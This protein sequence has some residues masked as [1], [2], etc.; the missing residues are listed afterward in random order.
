MNLSKTYC[1]GG[2]SCFVQC[3]FFDCALDLD[4]VDILV[5]QLN[6]AFENGL[7]FGEFVLISGDEIEVLGHRWCGCHFG[8]RDLGLLSSTL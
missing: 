2:S 1:F 6:D 3:D 8:S 7:D 4:E 5:S